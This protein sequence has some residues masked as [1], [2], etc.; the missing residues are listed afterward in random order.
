[1]PS[2]CKHKTSVVF[3][4][5]AILLM[6]GIEGCNRNQST[7]TLLQEAKQY[8]QKRDYK[9]AIIQLKNALQR[10]PD[11]KEARYLLGQ[12]YVE[13]GD[14]L[15]AE[16]ELDKAITL[17]MTPSSVLP[18]M[19]KAQLQAGQYQKVLEMS[20]QDPRTTTDAEIA[21][22]RGSALLSLGKLTDAKTAFEYALKAQPDYPDAML[23]LAKQAYAKKE[24]EIAYQLTEHTISKHPEYINAWLFKGDLLRVQDKLDAALTAY[25]E[26]I[27]FQSDNI[28]AL[29]VRA[30]LEIRMKK[31]KEAQHD[32]DLAK[33]ISSSSILAIYTQALLDFYQ[34]KYKNSLNSLQQVLR[35][36]PDFM[37][38]IVLSGEVE[39]KLGAFKQAEQHLRQYLEKNPDNPYVEKMLAAILFKNGQNNEAMTLIEVALKSTPEDSEL[40]AMAGDGSIL[41]KD[42]VKAAEYF[43]KAS[44][45]SPASAEYKTALGMTKLG[46]GDTVHAIADF[47][48]ASR[49]DKNSSKA[50]VLLIMTLVQE[51]EFDKA[52]IIANRLEN[53]QPK[54]PL[55]PNLKGGIYL[56]K[57]DQAN[58]RISFDKA[59]GIEP[60][61]FP[62]VVNLA[63]LDMRE[64][65]ADI[66]KKRLESLLEKDKKN[67]QVQIALAS[68]AAA[69]HNDKEA[70]I[71]LEKANNDYPDTLQP[72]QLLAAQYLKIGEQQKALTL[73]KKAQTINQNN[74]EF[75]A[76]LAKTQMAIHDNIGALQSYNRLSAMLP[77]S[78]ATQLQVAS[79]QLSMGDRS[80][81][82]ENTKKALNIDAKFIDAQVMMA[83]L[84]VMKSQFKEAHEIAH[85]VQK[86]M[87]KSP[88]GYVMDGDVFLAEK[89]ST[90]AIKSY[91]AA[92]KIDPQIS[93]ITKIHSALLLD[94]KNKEAD[95]KIM[96]W[97]K[98]HKEDKETRLYLGTYY[99]ADSR[100]RTEAIEQ[101]QEILKSDPLNPVALNNLAWIYGEEKDG[102]AIDY[103]QKALQAA[104][105]N[106]AIMDTLGWLYAEQG[107]TEKAL[108]LLQKAI[109][110]EP[111]A[112]E[113][114]YHFALT[115]AKSG[116]K[117][118]ARKVLEQ[119]VN[120]KNFRQMEDAKN[121]L[122]QL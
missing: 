32:I 81:A 25:S 91:E 60:N 46:L 37:P 122:K 41:T 33:K 71:W 56:Y 10:D 86:Q 19:I 1:M 84:L 35:S 101:F 66:A 58:A 29:I 62:A 15:S 12:I 112:Q 77:E 75:M 42:Y 39:Y 44:A 95:L 53:E 38:A 13:E 3:I 54:N 48:I 85:Q 8:R 31:F 83:S 89:K 57:K 63:R 61:F 28:I 105:N 78:A 117:A 36:L 18:T 69:R 11:S 43:E 65:K 73:V 100:T 94:G 68:L 4:A 106:P 107:M 72:V 14:P 97:L 40:L 109:V 98:E 23:G 2:N 34:E 49:L 17:G 121:T 104:P 16:K 92:Q 116:D 76:L 55:I 108:S 52:L 96:Q 47:E 113:I 103:A 102:R 59:V 70:Q 111:E 67:L 22:I 24:I 9:A 110:L 88:I 120:G 114:R 6:A 79:V 64:N 118:K 5:G 82:M 21:S 26:A 50:G 90:L 45:L 51:K 93:V 7:D 119:V 27:R 99:L 74:P 80:G 30:N 87:D 20:E 115:L